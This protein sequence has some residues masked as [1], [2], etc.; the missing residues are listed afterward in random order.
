MPPTAS[1]AEVATERPARYGRQLVSH[2]GR[3]AGGEWSAE[4]DTGWITLGEGRAEVSC[5]PGVL[6]LQVSIPAHPE[7]LPRLED[8]VGRHLVRF[9]S[10]D[11]LVVTWTRADGSVGSTQ[12][13]E[14]TDDET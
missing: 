10:K 13:G 3:K 5:T 2:L 12:R 1:V 14:G 7:Q 8:V 11:E 6:H 4:H 9:G